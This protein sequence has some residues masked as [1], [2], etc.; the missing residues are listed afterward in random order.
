M[1]FKKIRSY[2][3]RDGS[4][5]NRSCGNTKSYKTV[6][7][8]YFPSI[9]SIHK[10][11]VRFQK[12]IQ[13]NSLLILHEHNLHCQQLQLSKFLIGYQ[14]FAS[15]YYCGSAGPVSKMAPHQA[16]AFCMLRFEVSRSV[17]TV[18]RE[19]RARFKK[20]HFAV[21]CVFFDR[22][23]GLVVRV[24]GYRFGGP[25]SIPGTTRKKM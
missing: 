1:G 19:S 21:W 14:Q 9:Q 15:D 3:P 17:I 20:I 16:K 7:I 25:G 4:N 13:K 11:I 5:H 2:I 18:Q 12:L 24:L 23:S 22:L 6:S 8:G 10:N